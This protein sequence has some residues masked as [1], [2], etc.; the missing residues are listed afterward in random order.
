MDHVHS[1]A[2]C[3]A[4]SNQYLALM[5]LASNCDASHDGEQKSACFDQGACQGYAK[6]YCRT[7]WMDRRGPWPEWRATFPMSNSPAHFIGQ[8]SEICLGRFCQVPGE[9]LDLL[10]KNWLPCSVALCILSLALLINVKP[11][12]VESI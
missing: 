12:R 3:V 5:S 2:E 6:L 1:T 10:P 8:L 9:R 4:V 7:R 11:S